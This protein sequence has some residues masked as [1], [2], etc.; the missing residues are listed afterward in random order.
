MLTPGFDRGSCIRQAGE[1]VQVQ[2][3]VTEL[4]VEALDK[5]VLGRLAGLDKMQRHPGVLGPEEH[6]L[7]PLSQTM[8]LGR[9]RRSARRWSSRTT[10]VPESEKST[11]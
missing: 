4:A 2:A 9:A 11:T 3:V 7:G 5:G 10:R 1:P 8:V 6:G